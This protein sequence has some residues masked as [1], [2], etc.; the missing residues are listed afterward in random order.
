MS[1]NAIKF[2]A[3][4]FFRTLLGALTLFISV[5]RASAIIDA[6]LQMQLGNPSGATA[7]PNNYAHYLIQRTVEAIDYSDQY[8]VPNWVSWDLTASDIGSS[9]RSSNFYTDTTLP[10]NFYEVTSSDYTD[11]GW[12]RGHMC[13]SVDRTDNTNDNKLVFYMTNIIPQDANENGGVWGSLE[14]YCDSMASSYELLIT[15]GPSGFSST[16]FADGHVYVPSNT[17]KVVVFAP[18]G[19]GTALSRIISADPSTIRVITVEIPNA[20]QV[21]SW[22]SFVT[23]TRQLQADTGF[24]FF[25]ALP[26]NLAWI[27]RSKVDGQPPAA[28]G[29]ISFAPLSGLAGTNITITGS[30]LDSTT[31]V[32]F[33]GAAASYIIDSPQQ[34]TATVPTNV[35]TGP[36]SVLT[37]GG[38]STSPGN[39]TLTAVNGPDPAITKT[40]TGYFVQGDVGD[41]Y[42]IQVAN[43]GTQPSSGLLTVTDALP[44]GL[45]AT[46][47]SGDGWSTDLNSLTC[48]RS[49]PLAPGSSYPPIT[50][51]VNV[52]ATAPAS[53]TNMAYV[54]GGSD[55]NTLNNTASDP[56]TIIAPG[57]AEL[58]VAPSSGFTSSGYMGGPFSPSIQ[59]YSLTNS[60]GAPLNWTASETVNWLTL[61]ATSGSLVP[62]AGASVTV[63]I[64][65]NANSLAPGNYSDTI[66][67]TNITNGA[68]NSSL[69]VNLNVAALTPV[70]RA[71]GAALVSEGCTPTNGVVDP[72]ETVTMSF[73]LLNVGNGST[74]NLVATLLAANGVTDPS[75]SQ[76]YG[77]IGAGT[78][79]SQDFTFTASGICGGIVQPVLQLQDGTNNLGSVFYTVPLGASVTSMAQNF[80]GVTAPA[81]P[82]GWATS[83]SGSQSNWVTSTA[84]VDTAPNAAFSTDPTNAGLSE[85][86][87]PIFAVNSAAAQLTF[88]QSYNLT[89]D[90]TTS[91]LGY[92]GGVLE[93]QIGSGSYTDIVTAGGS[94]VSGGYN[95]T[96]SSSYA[97]P[98]AGRSAWSGSSV[99]YTTTVVNLPASASGQ[100]VQLRWLCGTG[101]L[102]P[103][104]P[105]TN[106]G[107][108]AFYNFDADTA[109]P[110][111]TGS[112][113]TVSAVTDANAGAITYYGGNPSSG[114]AIA[115]SGFT[116]SAAPVTTNFSYLAFSLTV[117][118]G[119]QAALSSLSL[120]D[121]A[122]STGPTKFDVQISTNAGFSSMIY[123]SGEKSTHT[124]F[125]TT[126]MNT[127]ALS[128]SNLTG[129]VYFR[130]YAYAAGG[131]GGTWR[132]DNLNVQGNT[133]PTSGAQAGTGWYVDSITVQDAACCVSVATPPLASFTAS[134]TN[135][136]EPLAVTF[137][138]TSSGS[139]TTWV[140]TFGDGIGTSTAQNPNY[141]YT[142]PGT[143][144][145][146][147]IASNAGGSSTDTVANLISVYDPFASWQQFY[148]LTGT[149]SSGNASYTGDGMSNT[150][151]F[152]AGFN[153][154]NAAAN[155][156]IISIANTNTTNINVTYLGA[157]GDS[158]W[159][160]GIASRTN[161]LEF[162]PGTANGSYTNNFVS[163]GQT[164]IL[165]GGNG[166]GTVTNMTDFGGA[167]NKPSR[168]Y[169]VRVLLP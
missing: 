82:T 90:A 1:I 166:L 51:T 30:N 122:S 5:Q 65:A 58:G 49:D 116:T 32:L 70:L 159:S 72:G 99:A 136:T 133:N 60:G 115:S 113:L 101:N 54:S 155:L 153:P 134:P 31:N 156:H 21:N 56:T 6:T 100:S 132:I 111:I 66:N 41:T 40:H 125:S 97:N 44:N 55:T 67:F 74:A 46:A 8:G 28:P 63:T 78:S 29:P 22:Q 119:Y 124:A 151:K 160:P 50:V 42:T 38:S 162:T 68:G 94:F 86:D 143:Y 16:N 45:T 112:N 12:T 33:N 91:T 163:T 169:R 118:N 7:D 37:L 3:S 142:S 146:T 73:S 19:S 9:G 79:A 161:V 144:A 71:D 83:S 96:L 10:P 104:S 18:L 152:M 89:A 131:S 150:N 158:T 75:G 87:S 93:I 80:D 167:T 105:V 14:D 27:L 48:T 139:P 43:V 15:C 23:S 98:L 2:L 145:V 81:L 109:I 53:V 52:S 57:P 84:L 165:S 77:A 69:P 64:N 168:F 120:D 26:T 123:D 34:I 157:N 25:T 102:P 4:K 39:F 138:D 76:N 24:S 61:S 20:P 11:S 47:I 85:L 117:S 95:R 106:N 110:N 108:L 59:V 128:I 107:T 114:E 103:T 164:N 148:G 35:T 127:F 88:R 137:T 62:G 92:D 121:R 36:I 17:W 140:W 129:T 141:T 13:P 130:I 149:L 154:T 135:G 126:P 147:L